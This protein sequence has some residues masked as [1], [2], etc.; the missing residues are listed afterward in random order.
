MT[1]Q[2]DRA[3]TETSL[4]SKVTQTF[5]I[6]MKGKLGPALMTTLFNSSRSRQKWTMMRDKKKMMN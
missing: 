6:N 4:A 1:W 3:R 2:E 5:A